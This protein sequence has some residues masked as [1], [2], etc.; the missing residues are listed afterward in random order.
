MPEKDHHK[1]RE[2]TMKKERPTFQTLC[3]FVFEMNLLD[4][5]KILADFLPSIADRN[6]NLNEIPGFSEYVKTIVSDRCC[7][8]VSFRVFEESNKTV[9]TF[10]P[11]SL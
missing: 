4:A 1:I 11:Q 6:W 2:A 7:R 5:K 8:C 3:C 10:R 9:Q